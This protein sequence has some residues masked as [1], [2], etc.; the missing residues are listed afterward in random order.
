MLLLGCRCSSGRPPGRFQLRTAAETRRAVQ[1]QPCSPA[2]RSTAAPAAVPAGGDRV[3]MCRPLLLTALVCVT[4]ALPAVQKPHY[5]VTTERPSAR[6][7]SYEIK[8][9]NDAGKCDVLKAG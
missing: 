7:S 6:P 1:L 8:L 2:A 4:D 5:L 3:H 9:L